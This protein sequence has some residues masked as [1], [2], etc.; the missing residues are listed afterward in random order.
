MLVGRAGQRGTARGCA[1]FFVVFDSMDQRRNGNKCRAC[2][3]FVKVFVESAGSPGRA[4]S[5]TRTRA[6]TQ[7]PR[8]CLALASRCLVLRSAGLVGLRERVA[9]V[10]DVIGTRHG[11]SAVLFLFRLRG[12]LRLNL[13]LVSAVGV[14]CLV[15][16]CQQGG[17]E[18]EGER[19]GGG[20]GANERAF[21]TLLLWV[22][23]RRVTMSE[24]GGTA[25][26]CH[27]STRTL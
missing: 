11:G 22:M 24:R 23:V 1:P 16:F 6:R 5:S 19:E 8:A 10:I 20:R 26:R 7:E 21:F 13:A 2:V 3:F 17:S 15:L 12:A 9:G 25:L 14:A 4:F 27:P 18:S